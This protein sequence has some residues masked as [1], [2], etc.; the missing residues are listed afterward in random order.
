MATK[1]K[2]MSNEH[3]QALAAG[4]TESRAVKAYLDALDQ[5]RPRRGRRRTPQ[6]IQKRLIAIESQLDSASSLAR[7]QLIQERRDLTAELQTLGKDSDMTALEEAFVKVAKDYGTRKAIDY[8]SWRDI[9]V[10]ADVLKRAGIGRSG[11]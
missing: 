8:S 5:Q 1:K 9:G 2:A 11:S 10:P 7:L 3:K 4:R 6:S